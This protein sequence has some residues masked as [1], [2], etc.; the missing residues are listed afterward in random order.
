L[1]FFEII[2]LHVK[3]IGILI[4]AIDRKKQ[5]EPGSELEKWKNDLTTFEKAQKEKEQRLDR[6]YAWFSSILYG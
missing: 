5:P 4:P 6:R 1:F 2:S 3:L